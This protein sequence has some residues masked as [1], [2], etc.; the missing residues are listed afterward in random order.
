MKTDT[1]IIATNTGPSDPMDKDTI[2]AM[3]L[4][5]DTFV[6]KADDD[7]WVTAKDLDLVSDTMSTAGS[8]MRWGPTKA[9]R[10]TK[11]GHRQH[12]AILWDIPHGQ[13]WNQ[14]CYSVPNTI[15]GIYFPRPD[16]CV[17]VAWKQWGEWDVP[18]QGCSS[19]S[20][21]NAV[22][23]LTPQE[24]I[25]LGHVAWGLKMSETE[26][27]YGGTEL[28]ADKLKWQDGWTIQPG[29]FNGV[30]YE[31]GTKEKMFDRMKTGNRPAGVDRF[32]S[33]PLYKGL[34]VDFVDTQA[35]KKAA[36]DTKQAGYWVNGNNC[37]N[38]VVKIMSKFSTLPVVPNPN[39]NPALW[40]PNF[41]F[42]SIKAD[43]WSINNPF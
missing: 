21:I 22:V 13:N 19:K 30:W 24:P 3:G 32:W 31:S 38:H 26:W 29:Q 34:K 27:F 43:E 9:D 2:K 41:W 40:A 11:P 12:S 42:A 15:N 1:F 10:C 36:M 25:N 35:G 8:T 17:E 5:E 7:D 20:D 39:N 37:M 14:A 16:R 28:S 6:K 23:F 33:Y 18:D 4:A